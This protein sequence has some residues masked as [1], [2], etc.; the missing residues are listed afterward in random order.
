MFD[1]R[2]VDELSGPALSDA[3]AASRK[4]LM[5]AEARQFVLA[6]QWADHHAGDFVE[7]HLSTLPGMPRLVPLRGGSTG[8]VDGC[9]QI[10]EYAGA[11]LAA[12][13]GCSTVAGEQLIADA[14]VLRHRHPLMWTALKAGQARAWLAAKVAR[15]CVQARLDQ[16][17]AGWVDAETTPYVTTLPPGRFL[18][19]VDARIIEA[20]PAAAEERA[21]ARA[22]A[23]FVHAGATDEQGLR[24][25]VARASAG[26]V[27]YVVAVLDR[28]AVIL[29]QGGDPRSVDERRADALR[30]LANPA[31]A[32]ALLTGAT[33][34]EVDPAVETPDELAHEATFPCGDGAGLVDAEGQPLPGVP[35]LADLPLLGE[36]EL[37]GALG[38]VASS[39]ST[40]QVGAGGPAPTEEGLDPA[41]L[42]AL[43]AALADFDATRLDPATVFHVHVTDETLVSGRGVARVEG[44][45]P[46]VLR[47]VR[48]WLVSPFCPGDLRHRLGVLPVLD[49]EAVVPVDRYEV[50]RPMSRLAAFRNPYEV[51]PWGTLRSRSAD[52]DHARP[53]RADGPPGQ[54][55]LDN[56][57]KLSRFHHRLKT[58]GGWVVRT[59]EQGEYWWRTPTGHWFKVDATGTHHHGRDPARDRRLAED[60]A[61]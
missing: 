6:A 16:S 31:R 58:N 60:P 7:D 54:T 52:D 51:F 34:E 17:Q 36:A 39:H 56:L 8:S 48:D 15:R 35:D 2:D 53:Y 18:S 37:A 20:D 27:T 5:A 11:E 28:I 44:L 22:L 38:D 57:A 1:I 26:D 19:L 3:L 47:E 12:L 42:R 59:W 4:Q 45:G 32:L 25:L 50:P 43:I 23:R 61:A 10:E 24:T 55:R 30:I 9:P 41:L 13:L 46:M 33:L 49:A 29:A 21:R 14:V 40:G